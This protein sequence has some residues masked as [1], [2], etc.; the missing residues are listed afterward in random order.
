MLGNPKPLTGR[1]RKERLF[2]EVAITLQGPEDGWSLVKK[3]HHK[4]SE[5]EKNQGEKVCIEAN[6]EVG[7]E[8]NPG[9]LQR[10]TRKALLSENKTSGLPRKNNIVALG[11]QIRKGGT[12]PVR[13]E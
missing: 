9:R 4:N 11:G 6:Y 8:S 2:K 7:I 13:R 1:Q 12:G 5:L 10:E 3:H